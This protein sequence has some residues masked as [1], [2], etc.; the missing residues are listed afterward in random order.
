MNITINASNPEDVIRAREMLFAGSLDAKRPNAWE[1][2]GWPEHVTFPA[3]LRAYKRTGPGNAAVSR[4]L[5][6]CWRKQPAIKRGGDEGES[7][8]DKLLKPFWGKV[9][10][11]DERNLVGRYAGLI[12]RL[13]DGLALREEVARA[14]ALVDVAPV[15]EDQLKVTAWEMDVNST[16]YAMPT[17]YQYRRRS[18]ASDGDGQGR[19][20]EWADVHWSR[21][22]VWAEGSA[23]GDMFD[24]VP[25]LEAGYNSL[26]NLE[27]IGG[28]SAEAFL[29]NSAR[30]V[31]VNF[32]PDADISQ[33][34]RSGSGDDAQD[35]S[36]KDAL[37]DQVRRLNRN[38]DA[39]MVV[40]GASVDTLR[41]DHIDPQPAWTIAASEFAAAVSLPMT[42][43][44]G[45]QTGRLASGEDVKAVNM[46]AAERQENEIT[47]RINELVLKLQ[48]VGVLPTGEYVVEWPDVDAPSEGDMLDRA[49]KMVTIA[50]DAVA[51]GMSGVFS[52]AQVQEAAGFEPEELPGMTEGDALDDVE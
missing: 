10:A 29:K 7:D 42:V 36:V 35:I 12:L 40:Q 26:V 46:L 44:F 51:A 23:T 16:R 4:V 49:A 31:V 9:R 6:A 18:I 17:M 21:V 33:A 24:G 11:W 48:Q 2:Y 1:T 45:Q 27:K 38:Q 13:A 15:W 22:L 47:P 41:V 37:N 19:P 25:W 50:K 30:N 14:S 8:A 5:A 28:G 20:D 3:M 34:V 52:V 43:L 32:G 39:G